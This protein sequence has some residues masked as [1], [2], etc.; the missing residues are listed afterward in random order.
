MR[1]Y[2]LFRMERRPSTPTKGGWR[3][4]FP[5]CP[6]WRTGWGAAT[7]EFL[8]GWWIASGFVAFEQIDV[9]G[10]AWGFR[11]MFGLMPPRRPLFVK[12]AA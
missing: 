11:V 2:G 3:L 8:T 12:G 1:R 9:H 5:L 10:G 7:D 4:A 6:F